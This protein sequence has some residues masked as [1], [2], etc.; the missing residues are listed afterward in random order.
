M[1]EIYFLC[2]QQSQNNLNPENVSENTG[3]NESSTKATSRADEM[4]CIEVAE[5]PEIENSEQSGRSKRKRVPRKG[6]E[7]D[8]LDSCLC[9]IVLNGSE[10]DVLKCKQAGCE[11]QWVSTSHYQ[12]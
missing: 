12:N 2:I 7:H 8:A 6:E 9:G 10:D 11:T 5:P 1:T 3:E 4:S